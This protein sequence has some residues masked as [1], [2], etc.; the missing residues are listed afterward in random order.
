LEL[1]ELLLLLCQPQVLVHTDK[2][3]IP[4]GNVLFRWTK[5]ATVGEAAGREKGVEQKEQSNADYIRKMVMIKKLQAMMGSDG[6]MSDGVF[7]EA[8]EALDRVIA[9]QTTERSVPPDSIDSHTEVVDVRPAKCPPRPARKGRPRNTSLKSYEEEVTRLKKKG[10]PAVGERL[11]A[12]IDDENPRS[13]KTRALEELL[14][15]V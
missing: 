11:E 7:A 6:T 3:E 10:P 12:S 15:H 14:N 2:T 5:N 13:G 4:S 1:N 8:M 9:R